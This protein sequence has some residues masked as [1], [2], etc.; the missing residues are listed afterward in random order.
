[1]ISHYIPKS[2]FSNWDEN[3]HTLT[4][5]YN[6]SQ[7]STLKETPY[8]LFYGRHPK[9][10]MDH[11]CNLP[12]SSLRADSVINELKRAYQIAAEYLQKSQ[13]KMKERFDEQVSDTIIK[14]GDEVMY[15]KPKRKPGEP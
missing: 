9:S 3:I 6:M 14:V 10:P 12:T 1:M 15:E 13:Q 8:F 7:H 4:H 5:A 2:D 11:F